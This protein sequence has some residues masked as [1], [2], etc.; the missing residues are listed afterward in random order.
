MTNFRE[1]LKVVLFEGAGAPAEFLDL[2]NETYRVWKEVWS[3]TYQEIG[4]DQG[5]HSDGFTRQTRIAAIFNHDTCIA[6]CGLR[7]TNF[8]YHNMRDDSLLMAWTDDAYSKLVRD[9]TDIA[10]CSY[11]TVA[12][13]FRRPLENGTETRDL[14]GMVSIKSFLDLGADVMTGTMRMARR[15]NRVANHV[16]GTFLGT[17]SM[18][19]SEAQL[20]AFYAKEMKAIEQQRP[21]IWL[22]DLWRRRTVIPAP[23]INTELPSPFFTA[24]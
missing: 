4:K 22:D 12:P 6:L 14:I 15:T 24:V 5:L 3:S 20:F 16:N 18:H 13:E 21:N 7:R 9:G 17:S 1:N 10:V 8:N 11:L 19:G 2:Y 23:A